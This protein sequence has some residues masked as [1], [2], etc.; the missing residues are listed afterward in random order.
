MKLTIRGYPD[1]FETPEVVIPQFKQYNERSKGP[2]IFLADEAMVIVDGKTG[3]WGEIKSHRKSREWKPAFEVGVVD[4]I[5]NLRSIVPSDMLPEEVIWLLE[6]SKDKINRRNRL[7]ESL[8]EE[9]RKLRKRLAAV[10]E[11]LKEK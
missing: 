9:N 1:G 4:A 6:G 11:A 10:G 7:T 5:W 2:E 3:K 8:R